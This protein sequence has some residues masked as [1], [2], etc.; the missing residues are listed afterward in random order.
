MCVCSCQYPVF[1]WLPPLFEGRFSPCLWDKICV[2]LSYWSDSL[3]RS[4]LKLIFLLYN[5]CHWW[6]IAYQSNSRSFA[7]SRFSEVFRLPW[8]VFSWFIIPDATP[9][10]LLIWKFIF[11]NFWKFCYFFDDF[12]PSVFLFFLSR[13]PLSQRTISVSFFFLFSVLPVDTVSL[14]EVSVRKHSSQNSSPDAYPFFFFP[15]L[16]LFLTVLVFLAAQVLSLVAENAVLF[17][18]TGSR[19]HRL[20]WLWRVG[21]V[22]LMSLMT[23]VITLWAC[24][25]FQDQWSDPSP[26]AGRRI[27][28]RS[29]AREAPWPFLNL[30]FPVKRCCEDEIRYF[31]KTPW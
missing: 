31:L 18:H 21:L 6:E 14:S 9:C 10:A 22:S 15:N 2:L 4:R 7:G 28:N 3:T 25:I 20:Q 16:F 26:C 1:S 8:Y 30:S 12:T 19:E 27:L 24:G 11:F 5:Q 17:C 29:A 23:S 13:H